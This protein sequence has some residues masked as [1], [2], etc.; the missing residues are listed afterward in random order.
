LHHTPN[1]NNNGTIHLAMRVE[2]NRWLSR[3]S[4]NV[5]LQLRLCDW[6]CEFINTF[7][8][9]RI[10]LVGGLTAC[11]ECASLTIE[12]VGGDVEPIG[13]V[14]QPTIGVYSLLSLLILA[15]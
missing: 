14:A 1:R 7:I 15:A 12:Q 8:R 9:R 10:G 4:A 11:L 13:V 2:L 3:N 5:R 6:I